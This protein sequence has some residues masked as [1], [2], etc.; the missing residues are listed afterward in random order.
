MKEEKDIQKQNP[1]QDSK[2]DESEYIKD[3][4]TIWVAKKKKPKDKPAIKEPQAAIEN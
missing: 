4:F 1:Q 3:E 2:L